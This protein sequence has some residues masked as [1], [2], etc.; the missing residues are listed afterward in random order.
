MEVD[1]EEVR[2]QA[3][4]YDACVVPEV[5]HLDTVME[6]ERVGWADQNYELKEL[7]LQLAVKKCEWDVVNNW[8]IHTSST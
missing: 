8:K 2:Q 7:V 5:L 6:D 1:L 4:G 3:G